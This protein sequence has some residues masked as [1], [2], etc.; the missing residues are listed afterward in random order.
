M[1]GGAILDGNLCCLDVEGLGVGFSVILVSEP[2]QL[3]SAAAL[4]MPVWT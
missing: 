2:I 3:H 4:L 1:A